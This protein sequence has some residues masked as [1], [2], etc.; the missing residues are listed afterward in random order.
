M[1]LSPEIVAP[2]AV[3]GGRSRAQTY[4]IGPG[5]APAADPGLGRGVSRLF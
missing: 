2:V 5:G 1:Q 3:I 4:A